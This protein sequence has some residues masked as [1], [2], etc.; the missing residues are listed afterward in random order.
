MKR[1]K[2]DVKSERGG[3][4]RRVSALYKYRLFLFIVCL[5]YSDGEMRY[6]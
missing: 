3:I 4:T 5:L 6:V 2:G 1:R